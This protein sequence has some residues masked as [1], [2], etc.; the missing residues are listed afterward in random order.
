MDKKRTYYGYTT[1]QQ[2]KL[3]FETWQETGNI[4]QASRQA[5]VS[6]GTFYQWKGRFEQAGYEG[7][8]ES[9]SHAP[10]QP[11]KK[12]AALTARVEALRRAH[13][14]W[15]KARIAHELAKEHSWVPVI[16]P[17]T[18]KRIL[19]DAGL[20]PESGGGEKGILRSRGT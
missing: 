3:L 9:Q 6:R 17:N 19:T 20:W 1:Y 8:K 13:P 11:Q 10:H 16:S 7:L 4:S 15:G 2:R 12:D 5:R 18:V 14:K